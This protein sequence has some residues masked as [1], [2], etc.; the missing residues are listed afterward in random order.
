MKYLPSNEVDRILKHASEEDLLFYK[1]ASEVVD[2]VTDLARYWGKNENVF[3]SKFS[4][5]YPFGYDLEEVAYSSVD[6]LVSILENMDC[7]NKKYNPT[8][9]VGELKEILKQANDNDQVTV[10]DKEK[11]KWLNITSVNLPNDE[12]LVTVVLNT[13]DTFNIFQV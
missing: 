6:W 4:E 3:N 1:K 2:R 13:E 5:G 8:I 7:Q 11:N 10:Y 9:T 12:G